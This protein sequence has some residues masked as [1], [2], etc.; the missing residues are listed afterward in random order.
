MKSLKLLI[1]LAVLFIQIT[2]NLA[3]EY[4]G[5]LSIPSDLSWI[6]CSEERTNTIAFRITVTDNVKINPNDTLAIGTMVRGMINTTTYLNQEGGIDVLVLRKSKLEQYTN[7]EVFEKNGGVDN[8]PD[9]SCLNQVPECNRHTVNR[10]LL[11]DYDYQCLIVANP[12]F[13]P[14]T[15]AYN[16]GFFENVEND[17]NGLNGEVVQILQVLL[18]FF[19]V[20]IM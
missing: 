16:I 6:L 11:P 3:F 1:A 10:K 17:A 5:S 19:I 7:S 9:F 4:F 18:I 12:N 2:P 20:I 15:L 8:Y 13:K 14:V